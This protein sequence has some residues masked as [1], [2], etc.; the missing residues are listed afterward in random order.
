MLWNG[1]E[2]ERIADAV[3]DTVAASE[4]AVHRPPRS[5]AR[6]SR[7]CSTRWPASIATPSCGCWAADR[8]PRSC[9]RAASRTSSGSARSPTPSATHGC[10][11]PRSSARRRCDGESF[12][13]VLLE[14]M[15]A[16]TP[17]VASAIEGYEN[18]A[19]RRSRRACSYRRRRRRAARRAPPG[20]R[21]RGAARAARRVGVGARAEFSMARLA[22]RYLELYERSLVRLA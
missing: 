13:V 4:R 15:A 2:I 12:G 9:A 17:I 5:R 16:S 22:E 20:A 10:A 8:R 11:A 7:C 3:P 14:A 21:R 19:R 1:I 6:V 18:V